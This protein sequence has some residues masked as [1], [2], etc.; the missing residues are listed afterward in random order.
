M[1][2]RFLPTCFTFEKTTTVSVNDILLFVNG[3][4]SVH[5]DFSVQI[6]R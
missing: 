4:K 3:H 6:G 2:L 1:K 5:V